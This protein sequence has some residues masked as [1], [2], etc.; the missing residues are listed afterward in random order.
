MN[1]V[2]ASNEIQLKKKKAASNV[3]SI[4]QSLERIS[5]SLK[6][7]PKFKKDIL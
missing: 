1:K 3:N 4:R 7:R 2:L 5:I 6:E